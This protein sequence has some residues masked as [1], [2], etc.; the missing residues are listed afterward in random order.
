M[1]HVY[2]S[3]TSGASLYG[4]TEAIG[5]LELVKKHGFMP[6][7]S[8]DT[9]FLTKKE[10]ELVDQHDPKDGDLKLPSGSLSKDRRS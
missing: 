10:K 5:E 8:G 6:C 1:P 9:Y 7:G 2:K 3:I 4:T